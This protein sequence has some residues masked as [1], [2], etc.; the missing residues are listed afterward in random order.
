MDHVLAERL[1]VFGQFDCLEVHPDKAHVVFFPNAHFTGFYGQVK[2]G[3]A[4]HGRQYG[5]YMPFLQ[6]LNDAL[7]RQREEVDVVGGDRVGHDGR[8]VGI[9]EADF[10]PLFPE[11]AGRLGTGVI[12]FTGLPDNNRPAA[13]DQHRFY[14]GILWHGGVISNW[15]QR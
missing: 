5:V 4:A 10:N 3:L 11:R 2:G 9:D 1:A 12:K 7:Y 14:G 8:R 6:D 13:Y 15:R